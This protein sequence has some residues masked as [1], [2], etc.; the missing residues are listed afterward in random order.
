MTDY[1]DPNDP[2]Y[3]NPT[4]PLAP[5]TAYEPTRPRSNARWGWL[6]AA[7]FL[8]IVLAL[9][10]GTGHEPSRTASNELASSAA[11]RMAPPAGVAA[12]APPLAPGVAPGAGLAPAP[13][14]P[15]ATRP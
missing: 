15:P 6:A 7:V 4:D 5:N 2:F 14:T 1:R 13:V 9:A 3:A 8:V 11:T 10:F 12:P